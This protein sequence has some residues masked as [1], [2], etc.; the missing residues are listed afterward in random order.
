MKLK[1]LIVQQYRHDIH[2]KPFQTVFLFLIFFFIFHFF[3]RRTKT[4]SFDNL[5]SACELG[6]L[7]APNRRSSDPSLNEKWQDHRRSLELSIAVGPEGGGNQDVE[8][9]PNGEGPSPDGLDS[10]LDSLQSQESQAG[11]RQNASVEPAG[12]DKE[13]AELSVAVAEGQMENI[14]QEA[15]KEEVGALTNVSIAADVEVKTDQIEEEHQ[16]T[17]TNGSGRQREIFGNGFLPENGVMESVEDGDSAPLPAQKEEGLHQQTAEVTQT[18]EDL[19]KQNVEVQEGPKLSPNKSSSAEPEQ[20]AGQR[21]I[22]NGFVGKFPEELELGIEESCPVSEFVNAVTEPGEQAD[23]RASLMASST[24]TLTEEACSRSELPAQKTVCLSRQPC[25]DG[26]SQISCS[27]KDRGAETGEHSF[28]RTL[29]GGSKQPS[30]S[31]FQSACAELSRDGLCN[32]DISDGDPCVGHHWFKGNGE[33]APLSRQVSLASCNSFIL[34]LRGS[35]S[36]HRCCHA[37]LSRTIV[38]PEQPSRSHLDD[39][40]LTLHTDAIQQ[41][42]RQIEAGHQLEVENLKKQ[43]QELWSRLENR[44]HANSHRINGDLGDEVVRSS[45]ST[46]QFSLICN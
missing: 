45:K 26:R 15:T 3:L 42:L 10:E 14:L 4:R 41:R 30:V 6:S 22:V 19:V 13:E 16:V 5:P 11:L 27:M 36:Q 2:P 7:L 21:M 40:G 28:S 39:D 29:N 24:E 35:C 34:H 31:A 25:N 46:M 23:K 8:V 38:S 20:P 18:P 17:I 33:R 43:V 1:L 9:Q 37:V 32:G 44:Q 12:E